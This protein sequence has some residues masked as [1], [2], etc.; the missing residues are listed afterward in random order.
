MADSTPYQPR[1]LYRSDTFT[2]LQGIERRPY[3]RLFRAD[4]V[5]DMPNE[6]YEI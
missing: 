1:R 6:W 3:G 5:D 4:V 2:I